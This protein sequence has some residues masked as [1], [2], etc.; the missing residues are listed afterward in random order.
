MSPSPMR[1]IEDI[2]AQLPA[3]ARRVRRLDRAQRWQK[4]QVDQFGYSLNLLIAFAVAALAYWS[5]LLRTKDF[6]PQGITKLAMWVSLFGLFVAVVAGVGCV[7]NRLKDFRGTA[8]RARDP[9]NAPSCDDLRE[10][11]RW[12]W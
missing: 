4:I 6:Y 1:E 8:A 3:H 10:Q 12:T 9:K 2:E 5:S 7:L 11:G